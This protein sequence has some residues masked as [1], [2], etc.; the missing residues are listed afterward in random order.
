MGKYV[1]PVTDV[2]KKGRLLRTYSQNWAEIRAMVGEG[3]VLVGLF[4]NGL[5][6]A[7][8][9]LDSEREFTYWIEQYNRGTWID[10]EFWAMPL[11]KF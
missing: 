6:K 8:P 5:Y 7:A 9:L 3:E 1:N 10:C 2:S 11:A 4:D